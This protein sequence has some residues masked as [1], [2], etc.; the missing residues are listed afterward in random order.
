MRSAARR[1]GLR[2]LRPTSLMGGDAGIAVSAAER[3]RLWLQKIS[4]WLGETNIQRRR[5][6]V[7]VDPPGDFISPDFPMEDSGALT[8]VR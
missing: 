3:R 5:S 1:R 7:S 2:R 6:P 8:F 4:R